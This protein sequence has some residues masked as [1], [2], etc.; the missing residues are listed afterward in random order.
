MVANL[1]TVTKI[2]TDTW[3]RATWEEF[4]RVAYNP[5]YLQGRSYYDLGHMR[6]EM[7][8]LG[9]S[10]GHDN[11][12]LSIILTLFTTLKKIRVQQF[13]NTSFRREGLQECQPDCAFYIGDDFKVLPRG[14]SP[15][16]V[17]LVGAPSLIIEIGASS[18]NDDLGRKR[19]LYERLGVREYWAVDVAVAEVFAFSVAEGRSGRIEVSEVLSGLAMATVEEALR[20]GWQEDDA[21]IGQWLME[22]FV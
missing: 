17:D 2:E 8:A 4:L 16:D 21:A 19:V 14:N 3:V 11:A 15:I 22:L 5:V 20:R 6:I 9:S 18:I 1:S 7:A 12:L 10:H 13:L